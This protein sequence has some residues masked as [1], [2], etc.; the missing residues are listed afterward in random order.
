MTDIASLQARIAVMADDTEQRRLRQR[1]QYPLHA[2][3]FDLWSTPTMKPC[4]VTIKRRD[5]VPIKGVTV[6]RIPADRVV[7]PGGIYPCSVFVDGVRRGLIPCHGRVKDRLPKF[8]TL[9][10]PSTND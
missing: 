9:E 10:T 8:I 5:G 1:I 3:L 6:G 2:E 4:A 7:P